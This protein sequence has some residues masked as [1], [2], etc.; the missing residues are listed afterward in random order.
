MRIALTHASLGQC[1]LYVARLGVC[2]RASAS[3][4]AC[5]RADGTLLGQRGPPQRAIV[6]TARHRALWDSVEHA[7]ALRSVEGGATARRPS[8][9]KY[10]RSGRAFNCLS[11]A[12][13]RT[14]HFLGQRKNKFFASELSSGRRAGGADCKHCITTRPPRPAHGAAALEPQSHG[15]RRAAFTARP[16]GAP[17]PCRAPH[18]GH[19]RRRAVAAPPRGGCARHPRVRARPRGERRA[20]ARGLSG[21]DAVLS[22]RVQQRAHVRA[23]VLRSRLKFRSSE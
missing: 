2:K 22:R 3:E 12:V 11:A 19:T 15:E 8:R 1:N 9:P 20:V 4:A 10:D 18:G 14:P 16:R 13:A 23:V 17:E 5:A 6:Y 7:R 21:H